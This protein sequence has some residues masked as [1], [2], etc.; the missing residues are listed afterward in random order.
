VSAVE[1]GWTLPCR[2]LEL[3]CGT[4][5]NA[6]FLARAGFDVAGI[7]VSTLALARA[8]RKARVAGVP[9]RFVHASVLKLPPFAE[10]FDFVFDRGCWHTL[11]NN[12]RPRFYRGLLK[13]TLPGSKF[14]L[15]TGSAKGRWPDTQGPPKVRKSEIVENFH[16]DFEVLSIKDSHFEDG[17]GRPN[18]PAA[19]AARLVRR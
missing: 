15:L 16:R 8:A 12:E 18:G 6:I 13:V 1:F 14:L 2:A 19:Y 9:A 3:G 17:D 10:P 4:G 11:E 7:D 5:T